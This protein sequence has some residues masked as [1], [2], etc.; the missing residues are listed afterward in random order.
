MKPVVHILVRV[1]KPEL[2]PV[3]CLWAQTIRTG[4]PTYRI[5]VWGNHLSDQEEEVL[6]HTAYAVGA[7]FANIART[8]HDAWIESL[9]LQS[10]E[11]FW[12]CDTDMVFWENVEGREPAGE[13]SGR[14]E[15][16]FEEPYTNTR[17]VERLHTCLM[18]ID[19]AMTRAAIRAF[20]SEI[21]E[22]WRDQAQFTMIRQTY[23]PNRSGKTIFYDTLAG[24]YQAG[25]GTAFE[26]SLDE[27]FDH[28]MCGSYSDDA[29]PSL[30]SGNGPS[31]TKQHLTVCK[32]IQIV[33]GLRSQQKAIYERLKP[34]EVGNG[35]QS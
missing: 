26:E 16:E 30:Q 23:I 24:L 28:L 7:N 10:T 18:Y 15:P 5:N 32:N 4:F 13:F 11:P 25:Y 20:M 1:R 29:G 17:H 3:A 8:G 35:I 33:R 12:I 9:I 31:L 34:K 14:F 6:R 19:P 22:L 27:C 2:M 21:P